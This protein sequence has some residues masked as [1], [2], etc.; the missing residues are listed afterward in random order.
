[1]SSRSAQLVGVAA[2]ACIVVGAV[3]LPSAMALKRP[4]TVTISAAQSGHTYID[5]GSPGHGA[6]DVD[7]Y[8]AVL[9]NKRIQAKPLGHAEMTCTSITGTTQNCFATYFL[10]RGEIVV[11]GV[12]STRLIYILAVVGGTDLYNNVRGTLTVTSVRRSPPR[13]LLVFRLVV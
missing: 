3:T 12:V 8:R 13:D 10:P 7:I 9:Y 1:M 6:G 5:A 4:G 2:V 11:S